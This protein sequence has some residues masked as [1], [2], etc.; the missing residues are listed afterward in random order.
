M[1]ELYDKIM[2]ADGIVIGT[3]VYYYDMTAQCKMIIDRTI[4]I[5]P[6]NGNKVGGIVTVA[7]S[8]GLSE[9]VKNQNVF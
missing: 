8:L 2:E 9:V 3:P 6:I 4:A 5:A 1:Q 7:G